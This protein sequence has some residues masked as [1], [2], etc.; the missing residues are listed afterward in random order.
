[1]SGPPTSCPVCPLH[2]L[3]V[4]LFYV[5]FVCLLSVSLVPHHILKLPPLPVLTS[6][7]FCVR[8]VGAYMVIEKLFSFVVVLFFK[9]ECF[10]DKEACAF[11][12]TE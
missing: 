4:F 3:L 5:V 8:P 9:E 7:S 2:L 11:V 6:V 1:M 12:K 10:G